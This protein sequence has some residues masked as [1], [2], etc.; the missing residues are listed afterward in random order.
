M[1]I[2]PS[3]LVAGTFKTC[4][5]WE[6]TDTSNNTQNINPFNNNL[7]VDRG[8][9]MCETEDEQQ[10]EVMKLSLKKIRRKIW[11][12]FTQECIKIK[13]PPKLNLLNSVKNFCVFTHEKLLLD[14]Q[15]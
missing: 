5:D 2:V 10:G 13:L 6:N 8:E 11:R 15:S 12:D 14:V 7:L 4:C 3:E 1:E 9:R